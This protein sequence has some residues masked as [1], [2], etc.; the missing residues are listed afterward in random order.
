MAG[1]LA[2]AAVHMVVGRAPTG[3]RLLEAAGLA[4]L[5]GAIAWAV[6]IGTLVAV[7]TPG[8]NPIDQLKLYMAAAVLAWP[9]PI[10]L[11]IRGKRR[12]D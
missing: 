12:R 10:Y 5:D 1:I 6:I 2:C 4:M 9:L 7:N 3:R 8:S 11:F